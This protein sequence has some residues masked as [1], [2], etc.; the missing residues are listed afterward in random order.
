MGQAAVPIVPW[1]DTGQVKDASGGTQAL[2]PGISS[3]SLQAA[4]CMPVSS[5]DHILMANSAGHV[6]VWFFRMLFFQTHT[7]SGWWQG[8]RWG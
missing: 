2:A 1:K 6:P 4:E 8:M 3:F 5:R 7:V